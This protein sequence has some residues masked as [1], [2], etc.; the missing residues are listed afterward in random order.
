MLS[1][2]ITYN[3]KFAIDP[4][5]EVSKSYPEVA[6][7]TGGGA[8]ICWNRTSQI[9]T[10]GE[11]IAQIYDENL[12]EVGGNFIVS[13]DTTYGKFKPCVTSLENGGFVICWD[14]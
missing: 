5:N 4:Y 8:V 11:I 2:S 9:G 7:L 10:G 14:T 6:Q 1:Q 12:A 3:Q 13:S